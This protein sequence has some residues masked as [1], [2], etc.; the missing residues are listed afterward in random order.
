EYWFSFEHYPP[1]VRVDPTT[2][3]YRQYADMQIW[4]NQF[5]DPRDTDNF[6]KIIEYRSDDRGYPVSPNIATAAFGRP[7]IQL[8]GKS[9]DRS[10]FNNRGSGGS[11]TRQGTFA[12][13]TPTPSYS[14]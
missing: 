11:F 10:F 4:F 8:L 7:D 5:I 12:D 3:L 2:R 9:S 14:R 1:A 6:S 13:A